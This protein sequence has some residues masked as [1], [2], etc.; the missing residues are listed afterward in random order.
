MHVTFETLLQFTSKIFPYV[1][2][3]ELASVLS[4]EQG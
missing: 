4:M 1:D 3:I 2:G